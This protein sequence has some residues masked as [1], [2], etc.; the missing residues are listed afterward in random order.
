MTDRTSRQP[1]KPPPVRV[2][3]SP[4]FEVFLALWQMTG[5]P[6]PDQAMWCRRTAGR[7]GARFH[8]LF[9]QIG[10][11]PQS[12]VVLADAAGT[13][14]DDEPF[15][16][17]I[18]AI[19]RLPADDFAD[20][21][22]LG[23]LHHRP[24]VQALRGDPR[25]IDR[26][27]ALVPAGKREWLQ[28]FGLYPIE[29]AAPGLRALGRLAT[30]PAA[31]QTATVAALDLFW[32]RAFR[33]SWARLQPRLAALAG[34]MAA[35]LAAG[36]FAALARAHRLN[37]EVDTADG[38]LAALR[39]GYRIG[40]GEIAEIRVY[41]SRFNAA[42]FWTVLDGPRGR[43]VVH[44]PVLVRDIGPARRAARA[45]PSDPALAFRALGEPTRFAMA[46]L[47]AA[48]PMTSVDLAHALAI[49]KPTVTHHVHLLREAGLIDERAEARAVWLSLR[50]SAI[51]GLSELALDRLFG[52][53]SRKTR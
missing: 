39:G 5:K 28:H 7:V 8:E 35:T 9:A 12:W 53:R 36:G 1:G 13:R 4:R 47:I 50:R 11:A 48:K 25:R 23:Q 44:V 43:R 42:G 2:V 46:T 32:R 38:G 18:A 40:S 31:V 52:V 27:L 30:D 14:P 21:M 37:I 16:D 51:A 17:T 20:R 26:A 19:A 3:T 15:E 45:P 34:T 22:L 24:A 29:P 41:P 49:S 10:A 33:V 6:A